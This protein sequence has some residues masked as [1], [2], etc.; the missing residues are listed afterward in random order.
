MKL[1][2]DPDY[3]TD[4]ELKALE[5]RGIKLDS[6]EELGR[7][8]T[9]IAYRAYQSDRNHINWKIPVTIT[10]PLKDKKD[11]PNAYKNS[12][13]DRDLNEI[14]VLELLGE[15]N[16]ETFIAEERR[17]NIVPYPSKTDLEKLVQEKGP[18]TEYYSALRIIGGIIGDLAY[19]ASKNILHRDLKPDNIFIGIYSDNH[20]K[21]G[22]Y[23]LA[24][25]KDEINESPLPTRGTG[26]YCHRSLLNA[27]L[28]GHNAKATERTDIYSFGGILYYLF[29]GKDP[30]PYR[31]EE[32]EDG[33]QIEVSGRK[34]KIGLFGKDNKGLEKIEDNLEEKRIQEIVNEVPDWARKLVYRCMSDKKPFKTFKEVQKYYY[35][36]ER[37]EYDK[38]Y[39]QDLK[40]FCKIFGIGSG[41]LI[42]LA[43]INGPNQEAIDAYNKDP[44]LTQYRIEM[45]KRQ[46][47]MYKPAMSNREIYE[48]Y[49][50]PQEDQTE[51]TANNPINGEEAK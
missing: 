43:I 19:A 47:E 37:K 3:F 27:W 35:K 10:L 16:L 38:E 4:P 28:T 18:I 29:T 7:G 8:K 44:T 25:L 51:S 42:T 17:I 40:R 15:K 9:R 45:Q 1:Q 13:E 22:D 6:I 34:M 36:L 24:G 14:K 2:K 49:I 41:L 12:L 48:R 26:T 30:S 21:L 5:E 11:S 50:K 23:Q 32:T 33:R 20:A 39:Y 46:S 31:I